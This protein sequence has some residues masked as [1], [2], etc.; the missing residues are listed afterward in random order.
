LPSRMIHER[1]C[2]SQKLARVTCEA[3]TVYERLITKADD[4][5]RYYGTAAIVQNMCFAAGKVKMPNVEK[6]LQELHCIGLIQLYTVNGERYLSINKWTEMQKCRAG[7]SKFPDLPTIADNCE[8][9]PANSPV[10]VNVNVNEDVNVNVNEGE[11]KP[12]DP[13]DPFTTFWNCY[14]RKVAKP[15]AL[16]SWAKLNPDDET[17]K[18]IIHG[19]SRAKMSDQWKRDNGAYIPHP[20]TFLNQRRWEDDYTEAERN[21]DK[22]FSDRNFQQQNDY[23]KEDYDRMKT[24][25]FDLKD[26]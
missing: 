15:V 10:N 5:G 1:I 21:A 13:P 6:A 26:L 20:A 25:V 9:M 14:P 23:E 19:L 3:E 12:P 7:K 17:V 2:T 22:D 18:A 11:G 4:Y 24:G 8:Q 16:K